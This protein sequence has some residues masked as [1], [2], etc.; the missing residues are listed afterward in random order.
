[1]IFK[2]NTKGKEKY[3]SIIEN[4]LT[5]EHVLLIDGLKYN[6]P[7]IGQLYDRGNKVIFESLHCLVIKIINNK[8][9]S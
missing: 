7:S 6:L 4:S 2:D 5:I 3:I 9:I 8:E 1:M